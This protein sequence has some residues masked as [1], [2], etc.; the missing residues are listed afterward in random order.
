MMQSQNA[1]I[2]AYDE[3]IVVDETRLESVKEFRYLGSF[4]AGDCSLDREINQRIGK[5]ASSFGGLRRR[6][7]DNRN[8]KLAT[9]MSVYSAV[10]L[11]TLLYG[12]K[13]WT[14]YRRHISKLEAYHIRC[15]QRILGLTW[16][17]RI[18]HTEILSRTGSVSLECSLALRQLRWVGHVIRMPSGRLPKQIMYGELTQENR[19]AGGQLKRYKDVT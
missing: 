14:I 17:D 19:S 6:V 4:L 3:H 7:F 10:C 8:I 9:K 11:S 18:P 5:A 16:K 2:A 12:A 13:T 15:L 1:N